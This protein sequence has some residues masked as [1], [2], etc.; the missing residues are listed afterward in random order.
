MRLRIVHRAIAFFVS[1][2]ALLASPPDLRAAGPG[3][4]PNNA[5]TD[6]P[7]ISVGHYTGVDAGTTV[8]LAASATRSGR[9]RWRDAARRLARHAETDL[10]RPDNM[11][12]TMNAIVLSGGSAY[13]LAA[14]SGVMRC[15]EDAGIGF[16]VGGGNV[17]PIVPAAV[18][19]DRATCGGRP[20]SRP[21]FTAGL[22]AC[23][24]ATSGAVAQGNV[25]AG[26]GA[27]AG[28]LK[29][30]IGS[31]QRR[32]AQRHHRRR[33][34]VGEFGR[35]SL[36]QRRRPLR[37]SF[38]LGNEFKELKKALRHACPPSLPGGPLRSGTNAVVATNVQLT[39]SQATKIAEMADD[40]VARAVNPAHTPGDGDT[41]FVLGTARLAM[42][43]LGDANAVVTQIGTAAANAV[44]RAIVHALLSA[45]STACQPSYCDTFPAACRRAGGSTENT[46]RPFIAL[47][48]LITPDGRRL[49]G[50]AQTLPQ[51]PG[52]QNAITD[53]PGIEVGHYTATNGDR[54]HDRHHRDH[55]ARRR[56][57][58]RHAAR[59][60][61]GHARDRRAEVRE[62]DRHRA[63]GR[64]QRRQRVRPGRGRRRD[65]LPREPG[66]RHAGGQRGDRA[67]RAGS[68]IVFDP[69]RCAPFNFRPDAS[70]GDATP[71]APP[72]SGP[73]QMGNVGAGAGTR[74][75]GVKG[76]L[77]TA[78]AMLPN[79]VV[80]GAI[81]SVNSSGR[82]FDAT[83][84]NFF[85]GY[86]QSPTDPTVARRRSCHADGTSCCARPP[87]P[88]SRPTPG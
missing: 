59:R 36:R 45:K 56:D 5:I 27:V 60:R 58:R 68:A 31:G 16:S 86:I 62:G 32:A 2:M 46:M 26:T 11:V 80:V 17:V 23:L 76:G 57:R 78:S 72:T 84:G 22:Q 7:G 8:V 6:V 43:T 88:S 13:G 12:E 82:T 42:A 71:A 83:T 79:G 77:G 29:G 67:A 73:V 20:A 85:A 50:T 49:S 66:H 51:T 37:A 55:R 69:G 53:V 4:G 1:G 28:G 33:A 19:F 24:A 61:A 21:D 52:P 74:S 63:R 3:P 41:L 25:G 15:L 64:A 9:R 38:A 47:G 10:M 14:A 39:K 81:V 40:G 75:G 48:E 54:R 65:D 30:G 70:F 87:S 35:R 18:S 34:R 44:S